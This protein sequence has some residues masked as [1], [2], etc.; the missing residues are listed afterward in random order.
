M[1]PTRTIPA[2]VAI[3]SELKSRLQWVCWR[4]EERGGKPTKVPYSP[5]GAGKMARTTDPTT[6]GVSG[7]LSDLVPHMAYGMVAAATLELI[8]P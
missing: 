7:W 3:P 8:D 1:Q 4:Y 2:V 6:W 5:R